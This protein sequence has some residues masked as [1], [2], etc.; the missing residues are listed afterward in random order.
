MAAERHFFLINHEGRS[1]C[2]RGPFVSAQ[3]AKDWA[4]K[5]CRSFPV[6]VIPAEFVGVVP[7][8][9]TDAKGEPVAVKE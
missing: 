8:R 9:P 1:A 5:N 6:W 3:A 2:R 7:F 4:A